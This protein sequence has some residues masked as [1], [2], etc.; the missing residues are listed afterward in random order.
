MSKALNRLVE[1]VRE[2]RES[3]TPMAIRGRGT[4]AFYGEAIVGQPLD[5]TELSGISSYEPSELV[6]TARAGTPLADVEAALSERGQVLAFEPPRFPDPSR[7][8]QRGGTVGGMV[9]TG[10]AGPARVS[11]GSVRDYVLGATLLNGRAEVLTFGGQVI[12]N[13]AGYD[14]SRLLAGSMGILGVLCEVS[15]KVLPRPSYSMTVRLEMEQAPALDLLQ[16]L[17]GQAVPLHAS[18]WWQGSLLL[19]FSGATPAVKAAV[20]E[21]GGDV[22]DP[23]MA[24][25]FWTGLRDQADE[26]F[27]QARRALMRGA[28]LWRLS[29]PAGA[30]VLPLQGEQLIEW[31]GA[32]RWWVTED[33]ADRVRAV[34]R[35]VGGHATLYRARDK[36]AILHGGTVFEP[37]KPPLDRIHRELK[38]SF[39]PDRLLNRGRFYPDL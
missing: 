21:V 9:A 8:G 11:A 27:D 7:P 33:P 5:V 35:S 13:V 15:L 14:V 36:A 1:R 23:A 39:D 12:K 28:A 37:L 10:L 16:R 17:G 4:K 31:G 18:A 19:R 3:G 38:Q 6:I 32:L 22:I 25:A 30:R 20:Q 34:A 29:V 2:A 24:K 26:Y